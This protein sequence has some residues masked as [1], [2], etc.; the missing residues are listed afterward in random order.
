MA[1]SVKAGCLAIEMRHTDNDLICEICIVG[2]DFN[3]CSFLSGRSTMYVHA[4]TMFLFHDEVITSR[5]K[6]VMVGH[7][8]AKA[9]V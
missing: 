3:Q 2:F 5:F 6:Q 8:N 7:L 4:G 1:L 9:E